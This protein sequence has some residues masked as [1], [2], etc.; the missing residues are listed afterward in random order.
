MLGARVKD[1]EGASWKFKSPSVQV[2]L[3]D[4]A[5]CNV[6]STATIYPVN[7]MQH[8]GYNNVR[9]DGSAAF[10]QGRAL[11]A[12]MSGNTSAT[13]RWSVSK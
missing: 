2:M 13:L 11:N 4:I 12:T 1:T 10:S 3:G 9:F 5:R 7:T 8:F 6:E